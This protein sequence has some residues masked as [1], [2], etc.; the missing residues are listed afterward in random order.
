MALKKEFRV[1]TGMYSDKEFEEIAEWRR[2]YY[3]YNLSE[4]SFIEDIE[5]PFRLSEE[6]HLTKRYEDKLKRSTSN[7]IWKFIK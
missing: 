2:I 3:D 5:E 6:E 7:S 4:E 1:N